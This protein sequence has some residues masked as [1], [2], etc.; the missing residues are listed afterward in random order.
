MIAPSK[1]N[2]P[3]DRRQQDSTLLSKATV[4]GVFAVTFA[5]V[6]TGLSLSLRALEPKPDLLVLSPKLE[7]FQ[8]NHDRFNTVFLGTSRTFYHVVPQALETGAEPN[9]CPGVSAFNF[10]VF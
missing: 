4:I 2:E 1:A 6:A 9:G 10:G 8:D 3:Q 5:V 7:Y